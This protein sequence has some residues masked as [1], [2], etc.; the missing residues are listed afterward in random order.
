MLFGKLKDTEDTWGFDVFDTS[1]ESY[2]EVD[3]ETH[4]SIIEQANNQGKLIKADDDG[5]PILVDPP[6]PT[7]EETK[8]R[9]INELESYLSETDW[10]AIRFADEGK[11]IPADIKQR[12]QDARDEISELR[13][14]LE[15]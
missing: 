11:P 9:R 2:I 5:N 6:P 14:E 13:E 15:E 10:Y 7:P 1:F 3:D 8:K 12:R 4:M